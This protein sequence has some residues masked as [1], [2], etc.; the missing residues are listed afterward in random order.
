MSEERSIALAQDAEVE[1][2][3]LRL[4]VERPS[5]SRPPGW[6][7]VPL[8][9]HFPRWIHYGCG[10]RSLRLGTEGE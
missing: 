1:V 6:N 8:A 7:L 9:E 2:G 10:G 3:G 4:R 5:P